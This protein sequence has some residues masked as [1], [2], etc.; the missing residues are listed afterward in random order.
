MGE[1]LDLDRENQRRIYQYHQAHMTEL[2]DKSRETVKKENPIMDYEYPFSHEDLFIHDE[3]I[4]YY[5]KWVDIL[6]NKRDISIYISSGSE[7]SAMISLLISYMPFVFRKSL[8]LSITNEEYFKERKDYNFNKSI[9][10]MINSDLFIGFY[11]SDNITML[12][13][14]NFA[15]ARR[16]PCLY[17]CPSKY[18]DTTPLIAQTFTTIGDNNYTCSQYWFKTSF[19]E[20]ESNSYEERLYNLKKY[21]LGKLLMK[22]KWANPDS[23]E[24]FGGFTL[25]DPCVFE[26]MLIRFSPN[27]S[28]YLQKP[29]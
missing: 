25:D 18:Y 6:T 9:K 16:I 20:Y 17:F 19:P 24:Y 23:G 2:A 10:D 11:S 29:E 5:N 12:Q 7:S 1:F 13:E 15:I 28:L 3:N 14:I 4:A 26:R 8:N 27:K 21:M 22:I